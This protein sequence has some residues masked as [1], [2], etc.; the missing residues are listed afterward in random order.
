VCSV[1]GNAPF[2]RRIQT[3]RV[4]TPGEHTLSGAL[5]LLEA[6]RGV[7]LRRALGAVEPRRALGAVEPRHD[8]LC[9]GPMHYC[10]HLIVCAVLV[11]LAVGS[12]P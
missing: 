7:D 5:T 8:V 11:V 3:V 9:T 4:E 2:G 12:T 10:G 6:V 1:R